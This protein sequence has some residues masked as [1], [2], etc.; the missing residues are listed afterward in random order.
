[1]TY[2]SKCFELAEHFLQDAPD[3]RDRQDKLAGVIQRAI[4]DWIDSE[5]AEDTRKAF[6]DSASDLPGALP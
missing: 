6:D 5:R 4:E 3:L 1:M 2:D